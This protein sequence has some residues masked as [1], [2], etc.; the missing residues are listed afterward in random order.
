MS[1]ERTMTRS[2]RM[3]RPAPAAVA[4]AAQALGIPVTP[5]MAERI[6]EGAQAAVAAVTAAAE[7]YVID[8]AGEPADYL[9]LLESLAPSSVGVAQIS[10]REPQTWTPVAQG[11]ASSQAEFFEPESYLA[12][13][14]CSVAAE[15]RQGR[16]NC[17][18]LVAAALQRARAMQPMTRAWLSLDIE[19]AKQRAEW[20][21]QLLQRGVSSAE[22]VS[23]PLLGIPLAHKDMFNLPAAA[24]QSGVQPPSCG[25][26]VASCLQSPGVATV[27]ERL[28][29]AGAVTLGTLHMA[30][31]ALGATGHNASRGDCANAHHADYISGGSSSGSAVAVARGAVFASLGSD[32]G[33]SVRI[34]A[35]V[36]GIFGLKPTYGLI[37]RSGSM[38][39][40]PSI[41]VIGPMARSV[42]DLAR[43]LQVVAGAD[44]RDALCSQRPLV[45]Y[46]S[47]LEQEVAGLRIGLPD[48]Y[49]LE[50]VDPEIS[51]ALDQLRADL[52]RVGAEF[53]VVTLPDVSMLA[54]LSRAVVYAEAT[55]L[56]SPMLREFADHYS[57]QVRLRASTGLGIAAPVYLA[58]LALR[59]PILKQFVTQ[60]FDQC[61]AL[62]TP[63]IP[64]PVPRRDATDVGAGEALWKI[65]SRLVRCTAPF[66]YLGLPAITIPAGYDQAG[67]PIGAQLIARP[68]AEPL[69]L[70]L[71]AAARPTPVSPAGG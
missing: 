12:R 35:A 6:A 67:L 19:G 55:G 58:A 17:Q 5:A 61:D 16:I 54:E 24:T 45:P 69:L 68:F 26:T 70:Q 51:L 27:I 39:L 36:N 15:L 53:K 3:D 20:M 9:G 13:D 32:T 21:E 37:P 47:L 33:G 29:Q 34:P 62:L 59:L 49:F 31:F 64:M 60:V 23:M 18:A 1:H 22:S 2:A 44:G 48:R 14:L 7:R 56:H 50:E 40:A 4:T 25:S 66:N 8:E 30:E 28:S 41:D 65:L 10:G 57:P 46:E 11:D 38:K 52:E 71:A 42:R 43:V 63:T